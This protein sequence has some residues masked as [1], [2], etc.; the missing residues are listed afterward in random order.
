MRWKKGT[1]LIALGLLLMVAA[2]GLTGY[3]LLEAKRAGAYADEAITELYEEIN[4]IQP[5]AEFEIPDYKKYPHKEMPTIEINENRYI[6][7]LEIPSVNISLPVM[8]GEWS[9]A[10]LSIAPC[11]YMGSVYEDNMVIAAHNYRTH[12]GSLSN[13]ELG[14]TVRFIDVENNVFEY[15]V[16]W[17]DVVRP[18]DIEGMTNAEEW[19]FSLFTC[20][21]SGRERYTLRCLRQE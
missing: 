11:R 20:T 1:F 8:A 5:A 13:V 17:A 3:N 10:K 4:A 12:F 16:G 2:L 15:V 19:D 9:Y 18:T 14:S 7:I 21:Y 6:G